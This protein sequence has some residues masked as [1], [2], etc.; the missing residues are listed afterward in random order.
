MSMLQRLKEMITKASQESWAKVNSEEDTIKADN[1]NIN[2]STVE[3]IVKE[4]NIIKNPKPVIQENILD[5]PI[6]ENILIEKPII[7]ESTK[8]SFSKEL[9]LEESLL[10]KSHSDKSI[11]KETS[12]SESEDNLLN[13]KQKFVYTKEVNEQIKNNNVKTR[14]K[15]TIVDKNPY[16]TIHKDRIYFPD[17]NAFPCFFFEL[18][19]QPSDMKMYGPFKEADMIARQRTIA[20]ENSTPAKKVRMIFEKNI[21][22]LTID[23]IILNIFLS[24][25]ECK[26]RF[27]LRYP[28][29]LKVDRSISLRNQIRT[30]NKVRYSPRR[31]YV[32]NGEVY[33]LTN[34]IFY[35]N[36]ELIESF[37]GI[38]VDTFDA[39][40]EFMLSDLLIGEIEMPSKKEIKKPKVSR[41]M[42]NYQDHGM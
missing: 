36:E 21:H 34:D 20:E 39:M 19:K 17:W 26:R 33:L 11:L 31:Q 38:G 18:Y 24:K 28:L 13:N 9:S 4:S 10:D 32:I 41:Y 42:G 7:E 22:R 16:E 3:N 29:L 40:N 27:R 8:K 5:E 15:R 30:G 37:F 1:V 2:L 12:L 35:Y 6:K 25:E 23:E 14:T